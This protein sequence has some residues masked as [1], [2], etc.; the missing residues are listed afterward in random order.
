MDA[1]RTS[2]AIE[3]FGSQAELARALGIKQPSVAGWG[4]YPPALRQVQIEMVTQKKLSAEPNIFSVASE[5]AA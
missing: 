1:M 3:F 4:E 2:E 5:R